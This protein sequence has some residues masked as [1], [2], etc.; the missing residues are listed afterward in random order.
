MTVWQLPL[1]LKFCFMSGSETWVLELSWH[2]G[3]Q[4]GAVR[5]LKATRTLRNFL[6]LGACNLKPSVRWATAWVGLTVNRIPGAR[7]GFII[8]KRKRRKEPVA[9]YKYKAPF[10][11]VD[12]G[13]DKQASVVPQAPVQKTSQKRAISRDHKIA[14][15]RLFRQEIQN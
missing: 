2:E 6:R 15:E 3:R 8:T 14:I 11:K 13:A 4:G 10:L 1:G 5:K 7:R 12:S 9:V